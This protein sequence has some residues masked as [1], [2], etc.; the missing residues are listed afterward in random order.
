MLGYA[1]KPLCFL[2]IDTSD[3]HVKERP[4]HDSTPHN[5]REALLAIHETRVNHREVRRTAQLALVKVAECANKKYKPGDSVIFFKNM[6]NPQRTHGV[7]IEKVM[8]KQYKVRY[9]DNQHTK[10]AIHNMLPVNSQGTEANPEDTNFDT[11]L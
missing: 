10:V 6:V 1:Q 4:H 8:D 5:A 2:Q 11:K 9:R 3:E 7:I